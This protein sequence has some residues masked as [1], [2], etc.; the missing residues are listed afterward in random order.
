MIMKFSFILWFSA[1]AYVGAFQFPFFA[2]RVPT[3]AGGDPGLILN[4]WSGAGAA[5]SIRLLDTNYSG[6][7]LKVRRSS[8]NTEQDIG[9][10][11]GSIDVASLESFCSATDGFVSKWYDQSGN[12]NDLAMA[13][14]GTQPKIVTSGITH[15]NGT[16]PTVTFTSTKRLGLTSDLSGNQPWTVA[17]VWSYESGYEIQPLT[18]NSDSGGSCIITY[19]AP[20]GYYLYVASNTKYSQYNGT[21]PNYAT[22]VFIAYTGYQTAVING[23]ALTPFAGNQNNSSGDFQSMGG[24]TGT[25]GHT[26]TI[27]E[28][29]FW[30][31]DLGA[32][33]FLIDDNLNAYF[34][35]H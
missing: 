35:A 14:Q 26:G 9:F 15:T 29:I 17:S 30:S 27:Q 33:A 25:R 24:N 23:S 4:Q 2:A 32:D 8:D 6:N 20:G 13:T 16:N 34:L 11:S 18:Y 1:A 7:C 28:L 22:S 10:S 5:F 19:G 31:S 3:I 21:L 12:A